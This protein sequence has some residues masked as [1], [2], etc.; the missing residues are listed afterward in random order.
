MNAKFII[1]KGVTT[2]LENTIEVRGGGGQ[3]STVEKYYLAL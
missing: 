1:M 3:S 2:K